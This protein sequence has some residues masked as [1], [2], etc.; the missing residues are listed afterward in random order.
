MAPITGQSVLVIGGS[1]GMGFAVAKLALADKLRV[2][3]ASSSESR[4]QDAVE[5]LKAAT[6]GGEVAGIAGDLAGEDPE[7]ELEKIFKAATKD[8]LLDHVVYTAGRAQG[9][10]VSE[11]DLASSIQ[12][13]RMPVFV[14]FLIAKLAPKYLNPGYTSSIT[15]TSGQVA[16]KPVPGYSVMA[17]LVSASHA[18]TR[19]LALDLAPRRVNVVAP[20]PT[21]TELWGEHASFFREMAVKQ[22]PL[23]KPGAP[24]DVAEAYI[25]LMKNQ[26]AT[27]SIVST[28]GG[29]VL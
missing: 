12:M 22:S 23:G 27:G 19:N 29:V 14:P 21:E 9:K 24:S 8:G 2:T 1:S 25:Y 18:L 15:F 28:N 6:P 10:P 13:A 5:R 17:A 26:D 4:V 7:A 20:G 3:I 11:V 16:E